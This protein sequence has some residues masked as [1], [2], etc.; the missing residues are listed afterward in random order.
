M[1]L[2]GSSILPGSD[3][4]PGGDARYYAAGRPGASLSC[5]P[6]LGGSFILGFLD[7]DEEDARHGVEML[8]ANEWRGQSLVFGETI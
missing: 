6:V 3:E 2:C 1:V 5:A 8:S 4:P 7:G